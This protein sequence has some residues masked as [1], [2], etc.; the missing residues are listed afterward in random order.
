MVRFCTVCGKEIPEG[1]AYCVEC[2]ASASEP[3]GIPATPLPEE[4]IGKQY[5]VPGEPGTQTAF[6]AGEKPEEPR[7]V[8]Y[9]APPVP[10]PGDAPDKSRK[11]VSFIAF[12]ALKL[13]YAIPIVGFFASLVL[14]LAPQNKNIRHHAAANLVWRLIILGLLIYGGIRARTVLAPVWDDLT[15]SVAEIV[16]GQGT[17]SLDE[18]LESIR[19][20]EFSGG[21]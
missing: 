16:D 20:G 1:A 8:Q 12:W 10:A 18:L 7:P 9:P 15:R 17:E 3:A 21:N 13:L 4:T 6:P 19:N 2:G 5:P 14:S 11:P